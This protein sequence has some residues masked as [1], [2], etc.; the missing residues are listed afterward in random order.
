[1]SLRPNEAKAEKKKLED[2]DAIAKER[3][4]RVNI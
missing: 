3:E 1:M 4:E 2:R